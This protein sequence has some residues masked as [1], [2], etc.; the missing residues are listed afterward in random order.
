MKNKIVPQQYA[1]Q[2]PPKGWVPP[3]GQNLTLL[4]V[5]D[6]DT[7]YWVGL[8]LQILREA[9]LAAESLHTE[10]RID[11]RDKIEVTLPD[12]SAQDVVE[13]KEFEIPAGEVWFINR[14]NLVTAA[15]VSGNI[16]VSKFP[17]VSDVEKKYLGT[18]QAAGA[19]TSYDLASAGQ[20][21][22]D[23]RLIGGDKLTVVGTVTA[24]GGTTADRK[25]TLNIYGRKARRLV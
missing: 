7:G 23:L 11:E 8:P 5:Y 25:V 24:V 2:R 22:A 17:K 13:T 9:L 4:G 21:G 19:T 6:N 14:F 1:G 15:E 16:R 20:L 12:T 18:D 3:L 10:D